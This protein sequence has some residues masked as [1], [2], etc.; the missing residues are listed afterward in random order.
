MIT[1]RGMAC[2]SLV[3]PVGGGGGGGG[4]DQV[5]ADEAI[6]ESIMASQPA[7]Q[8]SST[9]ATAGTLTYIVLCN[10]HTQHM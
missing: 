4:G 2:H 1:K 5:I 9:A 10:I 7:D 8:V 3:L 6:L